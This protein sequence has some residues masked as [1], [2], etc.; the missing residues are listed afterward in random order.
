[1]ETIRGE[2][3][4]AGDRH[5]LLF[6]AAANLAELGCTAALAH[7]LLTEVGLDCGLPPGEVK[8]QV[9]CGLTHGTTNRGGA[10]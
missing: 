2:N 5:R 9:E 6:S 8:R 7:E 1:M 4:A 3:L 10:P